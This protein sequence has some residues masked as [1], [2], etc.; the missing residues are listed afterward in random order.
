ML[1]HIV[2]EGRL[3]PLPQPVTL[4]W[5]WPNPWPPNQKPRALPTEL[6]RPISLIE[7]TAEISS[8]PF[9]RND[10]H[11]KKLR[12][13]ST[14]NPA[15]ALTVRIKPIFTANKTNNRQT[16]RRSK[17]K[18]RQRARPPPKKKKKNGAKI[19]ETLLSDHFQP[20]IAWSRLSFFM[21]QLPAAKVPRHENEAVQKVTFNPWAFL[22]ACLLAR[23][24]NS[25]SLK[26]DNSQLSRLQPGC[27]TALGFPMLTHWVKDIMASLS[28]RHIGLNVINFLR[29][30][31]PWS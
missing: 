23:G 29:Q 3:W 31:W 26:G 18:K 16:N 7:M 2:R 21:T 15:W 11:N 19:E 17:F 9:V 28:K 24:N 4:Y 1:L 30:N 25:F 13:N 12:Y 5:H 22:T 20:G 27:P 8:N 6:P 14:Q 10:P